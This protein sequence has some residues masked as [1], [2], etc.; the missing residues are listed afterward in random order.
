[1]TMKNAVS[2]EMMPCRYTLKMEEIR[3]SETSVYTILT[4]HHIPEDGILLLGNS[5]VAEQLVTSQDGISSMEYRRIPK[6]ILY[7]LRPPL[8]NA[9]LTHKG[10]VRSDTSKPTLIFFSLQEYTQQ[11]TLPKF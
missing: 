11:N 9:I 10:M 8:L 6:S 5:S 1:V 2:W 7:E 3:S 4:R